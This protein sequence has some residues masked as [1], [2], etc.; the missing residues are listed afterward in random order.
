MGTDISCC[1]GEERDT[2]LQEV[3]SICDMGLLMGAP[4]C[5]HLLR[6]IASAC[7]QQTSPKPKDKAL[8]EQSKHK[9]Q[10]IDPVLKPETRLPAVDCP[11]VEFFKLHYM[12]SAEPV[13]LK[14][15]IDYWPALGCRKWTIEYIKSVAGKRTVPI[16]IGARYTDSSWTQKLLTVEEFI[17]R[18]ILQEKNTGEL[19]IYI[20]YSMV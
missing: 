12:D 11:S 8:F 1:S 6:R 7:H 15:V 13:V 9:K 2:F 5:D 19:C 10:R 4:V 14:N 3:I 16:E 18:Y 17:D 20:F